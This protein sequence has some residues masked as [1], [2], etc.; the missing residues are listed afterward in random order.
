MLPIKILL[1]ED[2]EDCVNLTRETLKKAGIL[3]RL[4]VARTGKAALAMVDAVRPQVVLLD[5]VL[6]DISGAD[7]L[8]AIKRVSNNIIVI[9]LSVHVPERMEGG[10]GV[11]PD[12]Y[13]SKPID[14]IQFT[15]ALKSTGRFGFSIVDLGTAQ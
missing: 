10:Y 11:V 14:P 2:D 7:I 13:I 8:K 5:W 4:G 1:I 12:Y 9:I 15:M 6:P 3:N